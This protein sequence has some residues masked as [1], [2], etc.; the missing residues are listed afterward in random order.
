MHIDAQVF[1]TIEQL[2]TNAKE[3]GYEFRLVTIS[4]PTEYSIKIDWLDNAILDYIIHEEQPS[5]ITE[6]ATHVNY[7]GVSTD[8]EA[9]EI[10]DNIATVKA[11]GSI[12]VELQYGSDSDQRNDMG[13]I[14]PT[15]FFFE[16]NF[17]LNVADK[18]IIEASI[19]IDN[20]DW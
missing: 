14:I 2:R 9:I 20:S 18:S 10:R 17:T 6:K 1:D 12:S 15:D 19:K 7:E 11:N 3:L 5:D 8:I 4:P 13:L 16:G